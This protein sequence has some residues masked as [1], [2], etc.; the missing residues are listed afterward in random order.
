M[1][2]TKDI[3]AR[4]QAELDEHLD[5]SWQPE[6]QRPILGGEAIVYRIVKAVA[7]GIDRGLGQGRHNK[8]CCCK[9][10]KPVGK[11]SQC[12]PLRKGSTWWG[13]GTWLL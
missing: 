7:V 6:T 10:K 8:G 4:R 2:K 11:Y 9:G 3:V 13:V 5:P 12:H 1:K